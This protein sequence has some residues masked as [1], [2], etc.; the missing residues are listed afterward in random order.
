MYKPRW[1][2]F[3]ATPLSEFLGLLGV[4]SLV[5]CGCNFPNCPR[6]TIYEAS[7]RDVRVALVRDATSGLYERGEAELASIG[8]HL[9]TAQQCEVWVAGRPGA[10]RGLNLHARPTRGPQARGPIPCRD[11]EG[12]AADLPVMSG[13]D[14]GPG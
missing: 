5:V 13:N 11:N 2:A 14:V 8:V 10:P 7:E 3:F 6:T 9:F 1:G 12:R 4:D